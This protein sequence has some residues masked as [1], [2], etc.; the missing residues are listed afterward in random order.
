MKKIVSLFIVAILFSQALSSCKKKEETPPPPPP[1]AKEIISADVWNY[2]KYETYDNNDNLVGTNQMNLIYEFT[3]ADNFY[4]KATN[5]SL[6]NYGTYELNEDSDPKTLQLYY[7]NGNQDLYEIQKLEDEEM[8]LKEDRVGGYYLLY[9][10][11][12]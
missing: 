2:Y 8:I 9:F 1:S 7:H 4:I 3:P 6:S 10:N 11:R 12:N 5:G